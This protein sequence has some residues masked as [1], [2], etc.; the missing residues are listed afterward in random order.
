MATTSTHAAGGNFEDSRNAIILN[1][2]GAE[3]ALDR[4]LAQLDNLVPTDATE[5]SPVTTASSTAGP[6]NQNR[7]ENS[8]TPQQIATQ[9]ALPN[10]T[11]VSAEHT[12]LRQRLADAERNL[13]DALQQ[14]EASQRPEYEVSRELSNLR[15]SLQSDWGLSDFEIQLKAAQLR[16]DILAFT[17]EFFSIGVQPWDAP[18]TYFLLRRSRRYTLRNVPASLYHLL[19]RIGARDSE[20]GYH[21]VEFVDMLRNTQMRSRL[22][23]A[24][25]WGH[26]GQNVFGRFMWMGDLGVSARH[27]ANGI[28]PGE[29]IFKKKEASLDDCNSL[30]FPHTGER[31]LRNIVC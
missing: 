5:Q 13:A 15:H 22:M 8:R 3:A 25:V 9:A 2:T 19:A 30:P 12:A 17:M 31:Q 18:V 6:S 1:L 29:Y 28:N 10:S 14:N 7:A 21:D 23:Q 16:A 27:V 24:Y 26:L 4:V 11:A 20:G